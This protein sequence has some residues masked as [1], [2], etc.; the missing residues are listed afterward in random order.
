MIFATVF[1]PF[2]I[3]LRLGSCV[4][5][6]ITKR[7]SEWF[8]RK[9]RSLDSLSFTDKG[10]LTPP[11][12]KM[13]SS[14]IIHELQPSDNKAILSPLFK[15]RFNRPPPNRCTNFCVSRYVVGLNSV[16]LSQR[17]VLEE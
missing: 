9:I 16:S 5:E 2:R 17:Y 8:S 3:T 12:C 10:T 4:R 6:V 15:P 1:K 14:P 13:A 7:A 11:A